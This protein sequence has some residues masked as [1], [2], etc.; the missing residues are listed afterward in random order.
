MTFSQDIVLVTGSSKGIGRAIAEAFAKTGAHV[1]LNGGHDRQALEQ[2]TEEFIAKGYKVS[3]FLGDLSSFEVA[4][5]LFH[6]IFD[7]LRRMPTIVINN[8]GISHMGLFTETTPTLWQ[9][10]LNTNLGSTYN[11]SYLSTPHMISAHSGCIINIS[12]IWGNVGAS[13]EVAYATSKSAINGFTKALAKELGPSTIRVNAIACG[14][15]DTTMNAS[16]SDEE[17]AAF[18][19]EI[20]LCRVGTPDEVA[21]LCLY[22]ASPAAGYMTGQVLT[23]DGGLL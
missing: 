7:T 22:L 23:L 20:P 16:F 8:A 15:I 18:I 3:S 13:C 17:K 14:W 12:S 21:N 10:I 4:E 5:E 1:V 2:T 9:H 11:C 6:T 19:E